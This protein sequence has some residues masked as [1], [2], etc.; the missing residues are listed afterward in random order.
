M[1]E[2][3]SPP[4]AASG[5]PPGRGRP[6]A[7]CAPTFAL[8]G[9]AGCLPAADEPTLPR[10]DFPVN[11]RFEPPSRPFPSCAAVAPAVPVFSRLKQNGASV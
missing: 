4:E 6:S 10:R 11:Q 2:G 9:G 5:G 7:D 3:R 1:E 8:C